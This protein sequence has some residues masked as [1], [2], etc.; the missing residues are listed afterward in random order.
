MIVVVDDRMDVAD[1]YKTTIGR[2]GYATVC[3]NPDDFVAW[4][5][6]TQEIDLASVEAVVLGEFEQRESV[7]RNVK[8]KSNIPAIALIDFKALDSTLRLF[9]AGADD[10]VHKPVHARELVARIGAIGRRNSTQLSQALWSQDGLIIY[11]GG[12]D[13][14]LNGTIMKIP[15][16][17]L[18]I[19]EFLAKHKGRR[20]SRSQIFSAVYGV[21]D[22]AVEECVVE[23]HISKLRKK[24]KEVLGYDPI[25]TQRF[26]GYQLTNRQSVAA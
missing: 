13:I 5:N 21:L 8:S 16:R 3:F 10:V 23:S 25:D 14:E 7:T 2:E 6:S 20:V 9:M 24:L 18:R 17:E 11:G 15:R 26:L 22:E 12:R 4:F 19:L 1:A